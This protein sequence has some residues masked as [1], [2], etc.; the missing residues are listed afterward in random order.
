MTGRPANGESTALAPAVNGERR[1]RGE[2]RGGPHWI[3]GASPRSPITAARSKWAKTISCSWPWVTERS[4]T[5]ST[6]A[7]SSRSQSNAAYR[8]GFY[9]EGQDGLLLEREDPGE[10]SVDLEL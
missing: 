7:I 8:P 9:Q 3:K 6:A 10:V 4:V 1:R 5:T 2:R